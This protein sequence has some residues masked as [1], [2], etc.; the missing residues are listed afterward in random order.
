MYKNF[1][2]FALLFTSKYTF[3]QNKKAQILDLNNKIDSLSI[4]ISSKLNEINSLQL[5]NEFQSNEVSKLKLNLNNSNEFNKKLNSDILNLK[6]QIIALQKINDSLNTV[7]KLKSDSLVNNFL[8]VYWK[9]KY[10][11]VIKD[12]YETKYALTLNLNNREIAK[13]I[14]LIGEAAID[15]END[16]RNSWLTYSNKY[17]YV[18]IDTKFEYSFSF[19][20]DN[21]IIVQYNISNWS[22]SDGKFLTNDPLWKRV[23]SLDKS[24]KWVEIKCEGRGC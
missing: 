14:L 7:N 24:N 3:C 5:E 8:N 12:T 13:F 9:I 6:D 15:E 16:G 19:S 23:Y 22:E 21:K 4:V 11:D 2:L 18:E 17:S 20:N 10:L 1:I